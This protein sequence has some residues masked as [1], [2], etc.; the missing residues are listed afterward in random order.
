MTC[1]SSSISLKFI[2]SGRK[3]RTMITWRWV[4]ICSDDLFDSFHPRRTFYWSVFKIVQMFW[5]IISVL[6]LV[7]Q[8]HCVNL[9]TSRKLFHFLQQ[10]NF[11]QRLSYEFFIISPCRGCCYGDGRWMALASTCEDSLLKCPSNFSF[12]SPDEWKF[13][14][15][16]N[17]V[18]FGRWMAFSCNVNIGSFL[19]I[20]TTDQKSI[21]VFEHRR[22]CSQ[23]F[24]WLWPVRRTQKL[25]ED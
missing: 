24:A 11:F 7:D 5:A 13:F 16:R 14:Y 21:F 6:L 4:I 23:W 19:I 2:E 22:K 25:E 18:H 1:K 3:C 10:Q 20:C 15:G 8:P 17:A 9:M 12:T